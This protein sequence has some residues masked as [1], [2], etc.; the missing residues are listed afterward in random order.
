VKAQAGLAVIAGLIVLCGL[1]PVQAQPG[2]PSGV[3][4]PRSEPAPTAPA[5]TLDSRGQLP[6]AAFSGGDADYHLGS[7]DKLIMTVYGEDDLKS[8]FFVDGTGQAQVPLIGPVKAAG[9]S[10]REFTDLVAAKLSEGDYLKNP[11]VSV[12]VENY[13]PFY[14]IGEVNK[15]GEFPYESGLNVL[16]AVALAGGF[17]YRAD[18]REVYIRHIGSKT[19]A[20]MPADGGTKVSPGDIVRVD[21]RMF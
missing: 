14:I 1:L 11:R 21:E 3:I 12:Q 4:P 19:E 15:P 10:I 9:L 2:L 7:G 17:T 13:R 20:K 18:D 5:V 6:P 8:E 16:G